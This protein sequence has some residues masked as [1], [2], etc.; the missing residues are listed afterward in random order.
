MTPPQEDSLEKITNNWQRYQTFSKK[1]GATRLEGVNKLL[2]HFE[3]RLAV[4][5]C[6]VRKEYHGSYIGGLV[7]HSLRLTSNIVNFNKVYSLTVPIETMLFVG[8]FHGLG[9]VGDLEKDCFLEHQSDWHVKQGIFYEFNKELS[10]MTVPHRT[11]FLL[12]HFGITLS[13]EEYTT[14]LLSGDVSSGEESKYLLQEP[15]LTMLF[16]AAARFTINQ[17]KQKSS[18][19]G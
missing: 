4:T 18:V 3:N 7:D 5:P 15:P 17:T 10:F 8:L 1:T 13:E 2:E 14:I 16:Q 6:S 19:C 11:L 12:Q 9:K